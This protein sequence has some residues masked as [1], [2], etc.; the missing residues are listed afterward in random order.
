MIKIEKSL[1][2]ERVV[3]LDLARPLVLDAALPV[4][5]AIRRIR[6]A[7][8]N[9]ALLT[10]G[11][12]LAG[13]VSERDVLR[14]V[15]GADEKLDRPV[16]EVMTPE[17]ICIAEDDPISKAIFHMHQG[18]FR[19]V[20]VLDRAGNPIGIVHDRDIVR[21]LAEHFARHTLNLP[22]NP[23]QESHAPEGG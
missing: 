16:S 20:P 1:K 7:G 13:I 3:T 15:I 14:Q 6:A 23:N 17:P 11:G 8:H 19:H 5:E 9:C 22:P 12:R 2:Q 21:Y 4:R 18:G 10:R